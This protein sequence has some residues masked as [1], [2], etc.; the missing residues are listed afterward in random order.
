MVPA[1]TS[2]VYTREA[3]LLRKELRDKGIKLNWNDPEHSV[4]E[5]LLSLGD[6]RVSK[7]IKRAWEL[8]SRLDSWDEWFDIRVWKQAC[9]E[10]GIDIDSY[11]HRERHEEEVL[12][13]AHIHTHTPSWVLRWE[14]DRAFAAAIGSDDR[15]AVAPY[16]TR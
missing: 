1:R 15:L 6:R 2:G 3:V 12:P 14:H 7:A 8:G 5:A 11:V 16:S 13:W 4:I 10:C 9:E